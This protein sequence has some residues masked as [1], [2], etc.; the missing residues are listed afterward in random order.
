MAAN[1]PKRTF[2]ITRY[3]GCYPPDLQTNNQLGSVMKNVPLF[4]FNLLVLFACYLP[5]EF[6]FSEPPTDKEQI[7]A[8]REL[9]NQAI[10]R[11]D[12]SGVVSSLDSTYQ[13]TTGKGEL[14]QDSAAGE[15]EVWAGIFAQFDDVV[16]V[17]T[18]AVIE[19][20]SY[21]PRAAE[22]GRWIG[23]WTTAVGRKEVGGP[24][25]ASWSKVA[26]EWKIRSEIFVTLFCNGPGC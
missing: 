10:A 22:S 6:A 16:Y 14:F 3:L 17:R 8:I 19:I 20:S 21:L 12:V 23:S 5:A 2:K 9:S 1:D 13:I 25:T 15:A 11:H 7:G 24:Y 18:P 4:V 26:G